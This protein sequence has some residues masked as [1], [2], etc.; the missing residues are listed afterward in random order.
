MLLLGVPAVLGLP[1]PP[2]Q[3]QFRA[4]AGSTPR[5]D[6]IISPSEWSDAYEFSSSPDWVAEFSPA[7]NASDLSI[8]SGFIKHDDHHLYFAFDVVDDV[9]YAVDTPRWTPAGN[10]NATELSRQGWPWFGDELE[11]ILNAAAPPSK[12]P[13]ASRTSNV[14][15]NATAW[16][17]VLN[18]GK[19]RLGG[20]GVGGLCEGEPRQSAEAW[21]DYHEWIVTRKMFAAT[22]PHSS[23]DRGFTAEWAISFDLMQLRPGVPYHPSMEDTPMGLNIALG[24]VDEPA[25]GDRTYGLRHEQWPCGTK[26]GRTQLGQ[27]CEFYMM[28]GPKPAPRQQT[29]EAAAAAKAKAKAA[30]MTAEAGEEEH[31]A[32]LEDVPSLEELAKNVSWVPYHRGLGHPSD[33]PSWRA[34]LH[35][36]A[37]PT[38]NSLVGSLIADENVLAVRDIT[39]PPFT[40]GPW[41][42][43]ARNTSSLGRLSVDGEGLYTEAYLWTSLGFERRA[44]A[45]GGSSVHTHVRTPL[46]TAGVLMSTVVTGGA[47]RVS[48]ELHP[49]IR[50]YLASAVNCTERQ[51]RYP[52]N[53][54]SAPCPEGGGYCERNCWNWYAPRPFANASTDFRRINATLSHRRSSASFATLTFQDM[55]SG[56]VSVVAVCSNRPFEVHNFTVE[57]PASSA[58]AGSALHNISIAVAFGMAG[59]AAEVE[60]RASQWAKNMEASMAQAAADREQ[61]F[62][63]IFTGG[64]GRYSGR[65]PVL[66]T[67]DP[68]L[69]AVYYNGVVSLLELE[70]STKYL[71]HAPPNT[72]HAY[73]TG[74]GSNASTNA[75]FWD[76]SYAATALN[77]L[78]P[79]MIRAS[80][81]QWLKPELGGQDAQ[82]GWGVDFYSGRA[83][84][85]H[86]AAN[87]MTLFKL[88]VHYV[89]QSGDFGFLDEKVSGRPVLAW[90]TD[91]A[92]AYKNLTD[93]GGLADYGPASAL[94]EAVPTYQHAVASFNAANAWMLSTLAALLEA[95]G[96]A[97]RAAAFRADADVVAAAVLAL[98]VEG[99][100]VWR[101]RYPNRTSVAVRHVIDFVYTS[102]FLSARLGDRRVA[103]MANFVRSE[104][105]TDTWMRALSLSDPA[106]PA[107][108]RTD[109]GPYGAY[110][111]WVPLTIAALARGGNHTAAAELLRRSSFVTT[112]GPYGQAH[113]VADPQHL[114]SNAT[115]KPF[116][117][118][119]SNEHG[120]TAFVDC[121]ITAIMGLQPATQPSLRARPPPVANPAA[122]RGVQA[123]L[124]GVPWQGKLYD[125]AAG[126]GG[127]VWKAQRVPASAQPK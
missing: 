69:R 106:A 58:A 85:N 2:R 43:V 44:V 125:A 31:R 19:S 35:G 36:I 25:V 102:E 48:I 50:S 55:R 23:G 39:M 104:L 127:V 18:T 79:L 120:G 121:I 22:K 103:E 107:S 5:I 42:S 99:G 81:L 47:H 60:G 9:R 101:A 45:R 52:S 118:T 61:R 17:M 27:L 12:V 90:L 10:P 6:G 83:V 29:V 67:R 4:Y 87:D 54:D 21:S 119:L 96:D 40:G 77:M 108:D 114:R 57:W 7:N 98:Y 1:P 65:L 105:L 15:G 38:S 51:W 73:I 86:Y 13:A 72:S 8:K 20:I 117:F 64:H 59:E 53:I 49:Q 92:T 97:K 16:Q 80:L 24:D 26:E 84:G 111:G 122:A 113:G 110:D 100:G 63:D 76:Q 11:I 82:A 93:L 115:Y 28:R 116:E 62:A 91:F 33:E 66:Q 56:A 75:F 3:E 14:P 71:P 30:A 37:L 74:A 109:H 126:P 94:L 95:R 124:I 123:Q 68:A 34:P 41:S 112:L 70:R 32:P 88:A 89:Q 78:D 46:S